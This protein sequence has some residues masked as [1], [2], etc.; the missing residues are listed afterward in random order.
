MDWTHD[1]YTLT[2]DGN[3]A[4]REA[5]VRL[6]GDTYWAAERSRER[7]ERSVRHSL[8]FSLFC[9]GRQ[10]GM[11][12]VLTDVGAT[13]YLCDVVL[14]PVHRSRGLGQW[15]MQRILDHPAVRETRM[16]LV[17]RDAQAFYRSLGFEPHPYACM[18]RPGRACNLGSA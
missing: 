14:E 8:C 3:R 15:M 6:L 1:G 17:T 7:V 2:D 9:D 13:S 16:V 10:V 4:D 5:I 12:R 11:A 18:V